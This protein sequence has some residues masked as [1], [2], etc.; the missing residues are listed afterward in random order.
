MGFPCSKCESTKK[1]EI[2]WDPKDIFSGSTIKNLEWAPFTGSTFNTFVLF[3]KTYTSQ[4]SCPNSRQVGMFAYP[5][6]NG[7]IIESRLL[8]CVPLKGQLLKVH[9]PFSESTHKCIIYHVLYIYIYIHIYIYDHICIHTLLSCIQHISMIYDYYIHVGSPSRTSS[10]QPMIRAKELMLN[11]QKKRRLRDDWKY[12]T[13]P[14]YG[15]PIYRW[16]T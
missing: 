4:T 5:F 15:W 7:E 13:S 9:P 11:G 8:S 12:V 10:S 2:I 16:F 3:K 14:W 6:W 1:I